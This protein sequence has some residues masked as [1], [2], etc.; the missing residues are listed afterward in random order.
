MRENPQ[1]KSKKIEFS[2]KNRFHTASEA[3]GN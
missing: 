3:S 2:M 1:A